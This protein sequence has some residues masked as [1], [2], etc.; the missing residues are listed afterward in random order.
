M[1]QKQL[2]EDPN[3][4]YMRAY[5][6]HIHRD[7]MKEKQDAVFGHALGLPNT[8]QYDILEI[9]TENAFGTWN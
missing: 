3:C 6:R 5:E 1:S 8:A 4:P 9:G 7:N 2:C